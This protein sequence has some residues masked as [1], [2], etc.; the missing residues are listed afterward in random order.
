MIRFIAALAGGAVLA[1]SCAGPDKRNEAPSADDF[2]DADSVV[3][4]PDGEDELEN[5]LF[6]DEEQDMPLSK[7]VDELFDDFIFTFARNKKMQRDRVKFPLPVVGTDGDTLYIQQEA[8]QHEALFMGQDYYTVLYNNNEQLELEKGPD[9]V[10]VDVQWIHLNER[11]IRNY[12]FTRVGGLWQLSEIR[13]EGFGETGISDFLTFYQ[14]FASDSLFQIQHVAR[15]LRYVTV[16]PDD[17]EERIEGTL[18]P[19]QWPLFRPEIPADTITNISYGQ[20][21]FNPRKMMMAKCGISNG[22]MDLFVFKK[23]GNRWKLVSYEN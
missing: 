18:D 4:V 21:Y 5:S 8:W 11:I 20:T 15:P 3:L 6:P 1:L 10:A 9:C 23:T 19:E 7:N 22:M 14:R 17:E 2:S 12:H 16:D 13:T